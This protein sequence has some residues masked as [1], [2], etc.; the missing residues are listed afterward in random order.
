MRAAIGLG[1]N[2]GNPRRNVRRAIQALTEAGSVVAASRLY[3]SKPWGKTGQPDFCN[4]VVLID[5]DQAPGE[6]LATLKRLERRLGR[7]P[8][9]RW[10]PRVIDLDI[11]TY[12]DQVIE[13]PD[14][15]IPHPRLHE[16][17][18]ALVPLAEVDPRFEA[19]VAALPPGESVALMSEDEQAAELPVGLVE[20]VR[21]LARAFLETDL[22]RLRIEDE[23]EDAVEFR[24][25]P[26]PAA[27][28]AAQ[29]HPQAPAVA[30]PANIHSIKADLVG[31]FRFSRPPVSEGDLLDGDR[32]LAYV[33][34]LGIRNP[35]RS[36]GGGRI[37]AVLC[38]DG[39]PVEYGQ[40]LF[41]IDRG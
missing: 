20:R 9:E 19:A 41:E 38:T 33:D 25:R 36:L 39:Q 18:F 22:V 14:L 23:C 3:A 35:V 6:L 28:A 34:A 4:A 21:A 5:T 31:I 30:A 24:R 16:R 11:L 32:E 7:T 29:A 40:V 27:A 17:A 15:Q 37:I 2:L 1:S 26:I 13:E 8:G 10:G 12:G